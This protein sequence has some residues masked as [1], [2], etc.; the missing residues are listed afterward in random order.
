[1]GV[2]W[3]LIQEIF[4]FD[5]FSDMTKEIFS[6]NPVFL[7]LII[8]FLIKTFM[9]FSNSGPQEVKQE[10]GSLVYEIKSKGQWND[11]VDEAIEKQAIVVAYFYAVWCPPCKKATPAFSNISK[12]MYFLHR[13]LHFEPPSNICLLTHTF[14]YIVYC[15]NKA[16]C[17]FW[18]VDCDKVQEV[19]KK[20][21]I[22]KMPTFKIF[23]NG[24]LVSLYHTYI[25]YSV[26]VY[27]CC[28]YICICAYICM[29]R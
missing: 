26:I 6:D 20:N 23:K 1:M 15:T 11:A 9:R 19:A 21:E 4:H 5:S 2:I 28:S 22:A 27:I 29:C 14:I 18:K 8:V 3:D 25:M 12:C 17:Q 16:V 24:L 13:F 7:I 10:S